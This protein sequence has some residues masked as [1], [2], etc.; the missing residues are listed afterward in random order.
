[1]SDPFKFELVSPA[2]LLVS[3]S[4]GTVLGAVFG[5]AAAEQAAALLGE[6]LK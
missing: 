4:K 2:K 3:G 1:M 6:A 5:D